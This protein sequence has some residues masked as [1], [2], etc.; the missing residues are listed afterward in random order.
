MSGFD[1]SSLGSSLMG[2]G[3][4]EVADISDRLSQ[5]SGLRSELNNAVLQPQAGPQTGV[6]DPILDQMITHFG[7]G[8]EK[9][10]G[11]IGEML[12]QSGW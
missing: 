10:T 4:P 7:I 12:K 3:E 1:F 8:D 5:I 6:V 11:E 9:A 2:G